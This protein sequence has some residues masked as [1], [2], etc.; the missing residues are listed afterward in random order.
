MELIGLAGPARSGKDTVAD[1]L[2][3]LTDG[4]VE[5]DAFADRLK[6]IAARSLGVSCHP[7]DVGVKGI[8]RW[9]DRL[10]E[11]ERLATVGPRGTVTAEISGREFLQQLANV[12]GQI[13]LRSPCVSFYS[14]LDQFR[15]FSLIAVG[16]AMQL[17]WQSCRIRKI[18]SQES[19]QQRSNGHLA[20]G[21]VNQLPHSPYISL[22]RF[23]VR[24]Q[25]FK[26]Q[27]DQ[28]FASR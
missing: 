28:H 5:R 26:Q 6:L 11:Y 13:F 16:V 23:E 24:S 7:D 2:E 17:T 8:R 9:A 4:T 22:I 20:S 19:M 15:Q 14:S 25:S 21:N 27:F 1:I 18:H 10:K 12:F 3:D